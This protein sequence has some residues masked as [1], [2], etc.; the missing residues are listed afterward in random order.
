MTLDAAPAQISRTVEA[1]GKRVAVRIFGSSGPSVVFE[2][3]RG[4]DSESFVQIARQLSRCATAVLY[5][6]P[7]TGGSGPR[8][9]PVVLAS[10]VADELDEVLTRA[11]IPPPYILAGHSLGGLYV[12][13]YARSRSRKV[14][15]VLLI[16][17][18]SPL[19][20]P[21]T[22]VSTVL[23]PAGTTAAAEEAGVP[24]GITALRAGPSFPPVPLIVIAAIR[25]YERVSVCGIWQWK[26]HFGPLSPAA[27]FG[28]SFFT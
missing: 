27:I 13:A 21:D 16:D 26:C 9:E 23:P 2:A 15:A 18:A 4:E 8:T 14:A 10:T 5:D 1:G 20:P 11:F 3:G 22:F 17:A 7:G 19:E 24:E 6:R 28:V 25:R 12:Q